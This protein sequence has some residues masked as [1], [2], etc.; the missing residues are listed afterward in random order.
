MTR[1]DEFEQDIIGEFI[2]Q[3]ASVTMLLSDCGAAIMK[4]KCS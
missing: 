4:W 3:Y 2:G 1:T